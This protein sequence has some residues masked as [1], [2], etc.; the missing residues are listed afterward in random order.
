MLKRVLDV[1]RAVIGN[2][3]HVV[4]RGGGFVSLRKVRRSC[5]Q[6][7]RGRGH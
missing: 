5:V 6:K 4:I 7:C 2:Y 3:A 1:K